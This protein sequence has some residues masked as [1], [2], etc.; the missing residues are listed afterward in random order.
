MADTLYYLQG[1]VMRSIISVVNR[2]NGKA[3]MATVAAEIAWHAEYPEELPFSPR[4]FL[5]YIVNEAP[6]YLEVYA[7]LFED[8][9]FSVE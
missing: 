5:K 1:E 7:I 2:N 6:G 3:D 8:G 4:A 9:V